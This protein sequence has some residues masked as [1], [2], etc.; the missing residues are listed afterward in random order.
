MTME[1]YEL[2][3]WFLRSESLNT[4]YLDPLGKNGEQIS[5][6]EMVQRDQRG[7]SESILEFNPRFMLLHQ[8]SAQATCLLWAN[9]EALVR[10]SGEADEDAP[11][12]PAR[13]R[14]WTTRPSPPPFALRATSSRTQPVADRLQGAFFQWSMTDNT[15]M[16]LE[17][18]PSFFRT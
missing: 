2:R 16:A 17:L 14:H 15:N 11:D 18:S 8:A 5:I 3:V 4:V 1:P 13:V 12:N 9:M 10:R 7:F 6:F